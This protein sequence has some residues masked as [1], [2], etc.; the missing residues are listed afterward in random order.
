MIIL[1]NKTKITS[2]EAIFIF[3]KDYK[4]GNMQNNKNKCNEC[5][6]L[7]ILTNDIFEKYFNKVNIPGGTLGRYV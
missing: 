1:R 7:F 3:V 6:D 2:T 4:K 5:E